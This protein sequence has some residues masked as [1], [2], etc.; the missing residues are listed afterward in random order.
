[1]NAR[2]VFALAGV[3]VLALVACEA[4]APDEEE[5]E[6]AEER[7][8]VSDNP[9]LKES[10]LPYGA[11]PFDEIEHEHFREA[12]EK[13]MA[14]HKAE[15]EQI[16]GNEE[17][18][19]F[20]NTVVAMER[21]GELLAYVQRIFGALAGADTSDTLEETQAEMAP[22]LSAH[23]DAIQLDRDLFGRIDYLYQQRDELDLDD[24]SKRLLERYHTDF[25]RA[26][27]ELSD[28]E[29]DRLREINSRL[30]ELGA[31]FSRKVRAE[32]NDSAVVV[33]DRDKLAGLSDSEIESAADSAADRDLEGKYVITLQNTSGQPPLS[34]LENRE[35]RERLHRASLDRGSRGN[36]YDTTGVVAE[37]IKLRTERANMLGYDNHAEYIIAEQTAGEVSAVND[38]LNDLGPVGMRNARQEAE[39]L[40]N[41]IDETEDEP[42]ELAS[43]DWAFYSEKLRQDRYD[44]SE[45]DIRPYFELDNVLE[46]GVFHSAEQLFGITFEERTD[47][48]V[49]HETVR[50]WEVFEEDGTPLGLM[51]G[52]FYNRGTKRGGAWMNSYRIQSELIGDDPVVAIHLNVDRPSGADPT[53]LTWDENTTLFHEFGHAIHGLFSDV[54]YPRFAGTSVP[55]DFVEYPSQVYEMW[56]AEPEVLENYALHYETGERIPEDLLERVKQAEKFNEGFRTTEYL[57]ASFLD[58][59]WHQTDLDDL[60]DADGVMDFEAEALAAAEMDFDPVPPRYRTPYFN[61]MMGGY[62]AGY[63]SYIWS[64][65][66]DADSVEWFHE[67]GGMTREN[68]DHFR[69]TILSTGGSMDA[70]ELYR[71]FA[72]REPGV[73]ALL[74]RRGLI[75]GD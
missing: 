20:E 3:A 63:Y 40:Q 13:G 27:A 26:G 24:E 71:K 32:V 55:R 2:I 23:R 57:A 72:G 11:P 16:S 50:V 10:T 46:N 56:A 14:A 52:D 41:L 15:I 35:L 30:A 39:D 29:Q 66:L 9:L 69:D 36:D 67:Q 58:Q 43:W 47:L 54:T 59:A 33:E 28:E 37:T 75:D 74:E 5:I 62:S 70:M 51:Y 60:P 45:S 53:L 22:K 25:V 68:G 64:E 65:V 49:Y 7:E 48:P 31:E 18:P 44:F 21:S 42:F 6:V 12:L 19:T 73:E 4:D 34:H 8:P 17:R 38:M 1:M 61:H